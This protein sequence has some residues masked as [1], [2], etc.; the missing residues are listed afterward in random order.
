MGLGRRNL[1]ASVIVEFRLFVGSPVEVLD[2]DSE[3]PSYN[4]P[5]YLANRDAIADRDPV[6]AKMAMILD[7]L[8]D[9]ATGS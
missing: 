8:T 5:A 4:D 6:F 9:T 3:F 2:S 1:F 7:K